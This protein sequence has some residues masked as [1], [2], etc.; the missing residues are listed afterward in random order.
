MQLENYI[1]CYEDVLPDTFCNFFINYFEANKEKA[2]HFQNNGYPNFTKI[3]FT[4]LADEKLL[5]EINTA[6]AYMF[7]S[8]AQKY[9]EDVDMV[10]FFPK[11]YS[12]ELIRIKKYETNDLDEFKLHVDVADRA[13]STRFLNLFCYLNDVEEGGETTFPN[14][15][16]SFKPKRGSLLIFPPYWF[17]PHTGEKPISNPKYLLATN[18]HYGN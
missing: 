14:L 12:F 7:H 3:D 15:G 11:G 9:A 2:E 16:L 18:L 4:T 5:E 13:S 6:V 10:E 1:R 8:S 17:L